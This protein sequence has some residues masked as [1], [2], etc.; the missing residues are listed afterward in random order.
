MSL[1]GI[2]G[3]PLMS[4]IFGRFSG[5]AAPFHLPGAAFVTSA[6]LAATC[7]VTYWRAT[8]EGATATG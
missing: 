3:P 5:P 8:R 6:I 2:V 4:Q 7:W 1:S